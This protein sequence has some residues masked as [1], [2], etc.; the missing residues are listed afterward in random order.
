[1]MEM[2][3]KIATLSGNLVSLPPKDLAFAA[4]LIAQFTKNGQLSERQEPWVD[5]LLE[6]LPGA[7]KKAVDRKPVVS[8]AQSTSPYIRSQAQTEVARLGDMTAVIDL[9]K[10]AQAS[11]KWPKIRL[12]VENEIVILRLAGARSKNQGCVTLTGEGQYPTRTYFGLVSPEGEFERGHAVS[13]E[14]FEALCSTLKVLAMDPVKIVRDHAK[15]T[16][17][18]CF[19]NLEL[20]D[21]R[22]K[23]AGFGETCAIHFGLQEQWKRASR[24]A[25]QPMVAVVGNKKVAR[26]GL[27]DILE[28][29][30]TKRVTKKV[31]VKGRR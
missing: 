4:S 28:M 2:K 20:S 8:K 22:S 24:T 11:L 16:G 23:A 30:G 5:K 29:T 9:F 1:M 3:D 17:H 26:D 7:S 18:C 6:R 27:D 19:C 14:M 21:A 12:K 15:L 25:P 13:D 10:T 31:A